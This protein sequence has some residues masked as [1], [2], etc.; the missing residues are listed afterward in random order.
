MGLEDARICAA[1]INLSKACEYAITGG[2]DLLGR[3]T[4]GS[5]TSEP[6]SWEEFLST[7][8]YYLAEHCDIAI[9]N[10][11]EQ[12]KHAYAAYQSPYYSGSIA[13]CMESGRDVF[14]CG[15]VYR[16]QSIKCF[17]IAT[18]VDSLLAVKKFVYEKK[19]VSL[20]E[21]RAILENNWQGSEMLRAEIMKDSAKY[22]NHDAE[23]DAL[24]REIFAFCAD[25]IIGKPT[26]TGGVF[27]LGCDSVD[28][29]EIYGAKCGAS[30]DGR[31]D[32]TPLSKNM[33]PVNGMEKKGVTA[34]VQSVCE[35]DNTDFVDGAPLDFIMHPSAVEGEDGLNAMK[36]ITRLFMQK[37]GM[38]FQGNILSLDM[39]LDAQKN[40][41]KYRDLQVR[42]CGWNEYF[43]DMSKTVQ[44]DFINRV[45]GI[46]K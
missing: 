44:N 38:A 11:N 35:I 22:G 46:E 12:A 19:K 13:S 16:N 33:R 15:M 10:V 32:R 36:A 25:Q 29:A 6:S 4:V 9:N 23:A 43:V 1:W 37:G 14:N 2:Y 5:K 7:Y 26:S 3:V 42:V 34:F 39:L 30:A 40:P 31:Y 27:R 45:A 8:Y 24:T 41:E 17:A 28:T 21:L 18:A 20:S